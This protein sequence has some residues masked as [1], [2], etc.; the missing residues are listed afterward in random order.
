MIG[1]STYL[2]DDQGNPS[3]TRLNITVSLG[4][5]IMMSVATI[6]AVFMGKDSSPL[7]G[8]IASLLLY[9]GGTKIGQ[10]KYESK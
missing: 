1:K 7:V 4:V 8:V 9:S 5:V 2:T 10:K 6:A 3:S